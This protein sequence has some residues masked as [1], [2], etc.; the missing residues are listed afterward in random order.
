MVINGDI[1][2][3]GK[4]K[5]DIV[6]EMQHH[7]FKDVDYL[8]NMPLWNLTQDKIS[9]LKNE[10]KILQQLLIQLQTTHIHTLWKNDL[11][12]IENHLQPDK[13]PPIKKRRLI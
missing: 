11:V 4:P 2:F 7:Q 10:L 9:T 13:P 12:Q 1:K 6:A 5:L 8:L 3:K